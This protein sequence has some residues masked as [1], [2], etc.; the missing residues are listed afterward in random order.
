MVLPGHRDVTE[1]IHTRVP[2]VSASGRVVGVVF[3]ALSGGGR[4][5][6]GTSTIQASVSRRGVTARP[7][8]RMALQSTFEHLPHQ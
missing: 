2:F 6:D 7:N 3:D 8:E 1:R 5:M 4:S